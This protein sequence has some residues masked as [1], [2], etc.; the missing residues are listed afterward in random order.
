MISEGTVVSPQGHGYP[1]TPGIDTAEHV[2]AWKPIV[3]AVHDKGAAFFCQLWHVGRASHPHYQPDEA[4]PVGPSPLK[5]TDGNQA[6][7]LKS[8]QMEDYPVPRALETEEVAGVVAEFRRGAANAIAAG[9]DGVEV[10]SANGYIIDAFLKSECNERTD[11]YGG[12]IENRCRFA[13]EVVAAVVE[14][15]GKDKVGIRLSPFGG[16][17]S[18]T[19]AHPYALVSYLLEELNK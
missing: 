7:S 17:L 6:F 16:F 1:C 8:M 15:V 2:E 18:A 11:R 12:S 5:I 4:L 19:D 9:F 13:L 3:Q 10:H 14:E